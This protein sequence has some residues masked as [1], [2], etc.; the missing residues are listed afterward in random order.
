MVT[1]ETPEPHP[2]PPPDV[3]RPRAVIAS[4][5]G[6]YADPW[7]PF[8]ATSVRLADLLERDG[9]QVDVIDDPDVALT[10]LEGAALLVVNA[11]DPWRNDDARR[12]SVPEAEAG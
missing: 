11:G 6:R 5:A 7:H 10:E 4:G 1:M 3:S 8:A 9:W 2:A 12:G